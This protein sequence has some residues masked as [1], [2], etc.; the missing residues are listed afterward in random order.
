MLKIFIYKLFVK[1][2]DKKKNTPPL[3]VLLLL[4]LLLLS[5]SYSFS[6]LCSLIY[7]LCIFF[8]QN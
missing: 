7:F 2:I 6:L 3:N 5:H 1:A 4:L 8:A